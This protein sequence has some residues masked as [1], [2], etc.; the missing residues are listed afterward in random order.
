[1]KPLDWILRGLILA[2]LA[3]LFIPSIRLPRPRTHPRLVLL[4]DASLSMSSEGKQNQYRQLVAELEG[5]QGSV[6]LDAYRFADSLAPLK[7]PAAVKFNGR[8]TDIH[9]ALGSLDPKDADAILLVSDGRHN[10]PDELEGKLLPTSLWVLPIGKE[11][12]PDIGIEEVEMLDSAQARVRL[13]SNLE[14]ETVSRLDFYKGGNKVTGREVRLAADRLTELTV[15]L[16]QDGSK[17][18]WRVELDSLPLEDRLDNNSFV[19]RAPQKSRQLEVLFIA[20]VIS[21]ETELIIAAL[22]VL[23]RIRLSTHIEV[24]PG[25][26]VGDMN[27]QPDVLVVGPIGADL[28]NRTQEK[29]MDA[30]RKAVPIMFI[31]AAE[32]APSG[33]MNLFPLKA[34]RRRF[35]PSP[36]WQYSPLAEL[37]MAEW[38][39]ETGGAENPSQAMYVAR[40]G[41]QTLVGKDGAAFIAGANEPVRT[42]GVELP[43]L[44]SAIRRDREGFSSFIQTTLVYLIEGEGF[45]FRFGVEESTDASLRLALFSEV[46]VTGGGIQAWLMPDSHALNVIPLTSHSFRLSGTPPAGAYRLSISWNNQRFA[47]RGRIEVTPAPSEQPSRGANHELLAHL[48]H[49]NSGELVTITELEEL[50]ESLPRRKTF[51]FKPLKTPLLV[52]LVGTLFLVEIW[53]RR[54]IGLP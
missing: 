49:Q 48:A 18:T 6:I 21:Q 23:P 22:R 42:V 45:P 54:K 38:H 50:V 9:A 1:V 53:H 4:V 10:G 43:D 36:P 35:D 34:T 52:I 46:E 28:S 32:R 13:R 29:V 37:L 19:F 8:R 40:P 7:N 39:P 25:R 27:R 20:G 12:L 16:P 24:A 17:T 3:T 33:L 31:S 47:P 11:N 5:L 2:G 30:V 15:P 44:T 51:N 26:I 14:A 41:A